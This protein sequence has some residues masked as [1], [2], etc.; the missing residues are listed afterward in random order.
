ML[1]S[2]QVDSTIAV[3]GR[4]DETATRFVTGSEISSILNS[5]DSL[6]IDVSSGTPLMLSMLSVNGGS[7]IEM[8]MDPTKIAVTVSVNDITGVTDELTAGA[9]VNVYASGINADGTTLIFQNMRV[10]S[11]KKDGSSLDAVTLEVTA[12]ESLKLI[13]AT[14]YSSIYLGLV[15]SSGY[16]ATNESMPSYTPA[17]QS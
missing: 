2:I 13:Y 9:R 16:Q 7:S 1:T 14:T 11:V 12:D 6:R 4:S 15:D 8:T 10:L 3:A 5:G 17:A